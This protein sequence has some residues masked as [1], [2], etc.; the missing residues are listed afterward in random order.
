M[1]GMQCYDCTQAIGP[2]RQRL[3][4]T[5]GPFVLIE[6]LLRNLIIA[7]KQ[8]GIAYIRK[9]STQKHTISESRARVKVDDSN[10]A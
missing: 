7:Q 1:E 4:T 6:P 5:K 9:S 10:I 2:E 8:D 3:I